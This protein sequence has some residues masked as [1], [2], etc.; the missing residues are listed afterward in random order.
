M[1]STPIANYTFSATSKQVTLTDVPTVR[2]DRLYAIL[3]ATNGATYYVANDPTLV[4]TV[5]GSIVTLN[6]SVNTTGHSDSDKLTIIYDDG[7]SPLTDAQLRASAISVSLSST[8]LPT[9]AATNAGIT[10]V[11]SKTLTDIVTAL[12]SPLQAGGT[13]SISG[14]V[15]VS[16]T[17]WQTTQPVSAASLPLPTGA[18][19]E[20]TVAAISTKTTDG[21]Q[22]TRLTDGTNTVSVSTTI[23]DGVVA[24][25]NRLRVAS[26]NMVYNGT[27]VDISRGGIIGETGSA[28]GY[29]NVLPATGAVSGASLVS[30]TAYE[31]SRVIKA[32]AGTLISIAGYNSKTTN[33][34]IQLFN[35]T[36][37]PADT[38]VPVAT[39]IAYAQSNFS[40]DVPTTGIPFTTGI[41]VSNS[42]TGPTKT[43]GSADCYFTAVIK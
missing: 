15:P 8:P 9:G 7:T 31:A 3:N 37:V 26:V 14:T 4:A 2:L 10:G 22:L 38:A 6:S 5:S 28:T 25:V 34:F 23:S 29:L 33:Q 40:Y 39:F 16:G 1:K 27:T 24:A 43:I 30:S 20:T 13:V 18:A 21:T 17:F 42:S 36:S 12:G 35:A 32:S 19:T 41:C 11:S